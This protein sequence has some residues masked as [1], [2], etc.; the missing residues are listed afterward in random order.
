MDLLRNRAD[1]FPAALLVNLL[2]VLDPFSSV[3]LACCSV[4]AA[5]VRHTAACLLLPWEI[6]QHHANCG[7]AED[8]LAL[9]GSSP[10]GP[11]D[12]YIVRV[13]QWQ[14]LGNKLCQIRLTPFIN[15]TTYIC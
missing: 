5:L 9:H 1:L 10:L 15:F 4:H 12:F 13:Q 6:S 7:A 14:D 3:A 11:L 2:A 8:P